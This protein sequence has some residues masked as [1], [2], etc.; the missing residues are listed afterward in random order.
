MKMNHFG[1]W[2]MM[3]LLFASFSLFA[4]AS[5]QP[6]NDQRLWYDRPATVWLEALPLGNSR[7]GAMVYG[8]T[9][10]EEIQ[11]NEETFWSGGPH[12]NNSTTSLQYLTE[13]R[14]LI[15]DGKER[16]AENLIN[17]EFIKGPHGMRFLTV[18]SL[19][20]EFGHKEVKDYVRELDLQTAVNTTSYIYN[21]VKY[22]RRVIASLADGVVV[23]NVKASKKGALSFTASHKCQFPLTV[24][25]EGKT[26]VATI[27]GV[28]QEG[29]PAALTAQ[30]RTDVKADGTVKVDGETIKV[31]G[32]TEATLYISAATNFVNYHDVSGDAAK[33]NEQFLANAET[34]KFD[35]LLKRHLAE[36]QKQYNRVK[37]SLTS[38]DNQKLPTDQRLYLFFTE[39]RSGCQ[40]AGCVERQAQCPLGQ[41]IYH[42]HQCGDE[43]LAC[44]GVQHLRDG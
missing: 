4:K 17:K 33:K 43:L 32:A 28:E 16:D 14:S 26:L 27:Q 44:R 38:S 23:V 10:T 35:Q 3:T 13:V 29:I 11:L 22:T 21:N 8:G 6:D 18:G 7:M 24:K 31:E 30:C 39:R 9:E 36:Y 42:Q 2:V 1:Q 37:L 15:F 40:L 19:N 34:M 25:A 41:Q 20:L 5:V 12:N